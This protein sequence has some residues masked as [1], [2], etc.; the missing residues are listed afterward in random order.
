MPLAFEW[1]E[2]K[3]QANLRKHE[4]SFAEAASVFGDPMARIFVDTDDT[5]AEHREIIIGH[6]TR[7]LL[8]SFTERG[9][10]RV[11]IISARRVTKAER[12]DYEEN[13]A[14]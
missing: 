5:S 2:R 8:V 10:N 1:N 12:E 4:V 13:V 6:S 3:A 14:G 11:R 9:K 7:L